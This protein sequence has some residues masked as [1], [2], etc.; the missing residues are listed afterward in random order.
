MG[1]LLVLIVVDVLAF[2]G[3]W[4]VMFKDWDDFVESFRHILTPDIVS[5]FRHDSVDVEWSE[6]KG[7][8]W[9]LLCLSL[10]VSEYFLFFR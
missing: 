8:L 1:L 2:W 3:L 6:F 7:L 5:I 10:V 9:L 4:Y